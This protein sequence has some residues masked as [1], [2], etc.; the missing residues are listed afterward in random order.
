VKRILLLLSAAIAL[1]LVA[2]P[3][4]AQTV[5][6]V[7]VSNT[8]TCGVYQQG[9]YLSVYG[10]NMPVSYQPGNTFV[11]AA[12]SSGC[13]PW[14]S[15]S[16]GFALIRSTTGTQTYWYESPTQLNFYAVPFGTAPRTLY[17]R[18]CNQNSQLCTS[19]SGPLAG[20]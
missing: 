3:L 12:A 19:Y 7:C 4:S 11:F 20:S 2:V 5:N 17:L 13:S 10:S 6:G 15:P 9:N 1:A 14:A 18:V 8:Y 16:C